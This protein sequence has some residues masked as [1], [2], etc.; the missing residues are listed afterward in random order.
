MR[1][2]PGH[3][4]TLIEVLVVVAILAVAAAVAVV[5]SRTDERGELMRE[6]RR[7]AAAM[8][9]AALRAQLRAE[10]LGVSAQGREWR[11]W[12][13]P[14]DAA[15]WQPITS[16]D[17]LAAHT[18]PPSM[19]VRPLQYAGRL[20]AADAIIPLRPT[21]RNEPYALA[22]NG[23]D[24]QIVLRADLLNR[25]ALGTVETSSTP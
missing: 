1:R 13:R 7:L 23:R 11:F 15:Q 19:S 12:R 2:A 22:M 5:S 3:G 20:L 21:G 9:H 24:A 17:V 14:P 18:L 4:F 10:T 25:V 6:A 16:D 8:E